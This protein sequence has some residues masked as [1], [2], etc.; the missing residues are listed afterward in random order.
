ML[1]LQEATIKA[2][3]K[4][5]RLPMVSSQ[6]GS[7]AEQAIREKQGHLEYLE[8]LLSGEVDERERN[9]IER[10]I[11]DAHLPRVKTLEEF[12]Y[13]QTPLISAAKMRDLGDG[14]YIEQAEPVLLIGDSQNGQKA[15]QNAPAG[16]QE[17]QRTWSQK[18]GLQKRVSLSNELHW[19]TNYGGLNG[20][21][22]QRV[23][24][25]LISHNW[26]DL[27]RVAGSLKMGRLSASELIK[28]LQRGSKHSV[29]GRAL[30]E[31]G[32]IPKTL[33]LLRFI[34]DPTYRRRIL[35]QLNRGEGRHG[36]ARKCFHGQRGELRQR[37]REGQEDQLGALGLVLNALILWNTRY[38]DAALDHLRSSD[39]EVKP[40]D[41]SR[42]S[43][44]GN[45]HFNVLGRYQFTLTESILKGQLRPLRDSRSADQ[46]L[47]SVGA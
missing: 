19:T 39:V 22:R 32:R 3:C 27:L 35:T 4:M 13:T 6:F 42:L 2:H 26:D 14:K 33:H 15:K 16:A 21:A 7:L 34:D 29:L 44:L 31:L 41:A 43:P 38:M 40:D 24:T 30:G 28:S 37:Y 10:R 20:L 47:G 12:D 17:Q 46:Y 1:E 9:T 11:R 45:A 5:L 25:S 36:L 18:H 23:K 8:A